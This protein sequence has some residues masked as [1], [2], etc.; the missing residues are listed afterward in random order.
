LAYR[1]RHRSWNVPLSHYELRS[2]K[3]LW[4]GEPIRADS[5]TQP[6]V[7]IALMAAASLAVPLVDGIA[8]ALTASHSPLFVAWARYAA[9]ALIVVP[10]TLPWHRDFRSLRADFASNALRTLLAVAAMTCFFFAI[11]QIP[12]ATA[13][14]GFFLGPVIAA[15]L[16]ALLLGERLTA[17]RLGAAL[18][19]LAGA[20]LIV[21]PGVDFQVGSLLA[22]LSGAFSA[23]YL[24]ATRVAASTTPPVD[25]LRFQCVFG[26]LLLTPFAVLNWSW[27]TQ[28]AL[29]LIAIMGGLSAI[30]H[31]MLI[32]AFRH[33]E[34]AVLAPLVYL[35]LVT[36]M[37]LGR[38]VFGELPDLLA[39]SG[40]SLVV[41][42]GL[43]ILLSER[44][45]R[46]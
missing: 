12:F 41:L 13:F 39:F 43:S 34:A 6:I 37:V 46:V 22:V 42:A 19:G 27:P 29:L 26:A 1:C 3:H 7:G 14:G 32:A 44:R 9:A 5:P 28:E 31:F 4:E 8:K 24:V 20:L 15:V 36:A 10:L 30:C 17:W 21:R 33:G 38:V 45:G 25:A 2:D 18:A 16:A 35:E 23:G 40:I 11:A